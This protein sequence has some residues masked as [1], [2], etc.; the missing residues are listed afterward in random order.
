[1]KQEIEMPNV[2]A[3]IRKCREIRN[4]D[5]A[6]VARALEISTTSYRSIE[7]GV[8]KITLDY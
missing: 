7:S 5:Q 6:H 3:N 2:A 4:Y 8:T 1:M